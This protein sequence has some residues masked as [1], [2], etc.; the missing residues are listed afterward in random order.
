MRILIISVFFPQ[1]NTIAALRPY[2]WAKYWSQMGHEVTVLT[3][4][5]GKSVTDLKLDMS[6]FTL[7]EISLPGFLEKFI[8]PSKADSI[9]DQSNLFSKTKSNLLKN[10]IKKMVYSPFKFILNKLRKYG[11]FA[12]LRMPD[13]FDLWY[14]SAYNFAKKNNWDL[15]VSSYGPYVSHMVAY[16]LKK[17]KKCSKWIADYRDLWTMNH[18]FSA[19]VCPFNVLENYLEKKFNYSADIITTVSEPLAQILRE[20]YKLNYVRTI[21]NGFDFDDVKSLS[22]ERYWNDENIHIA[23]TG[24]VYEGKQNPEPM[25]QAI[26]ELS[27]SIDAHLLNNF[28]LIFFGKIQPNIVELVKKYNID[29]WVY[30]NDFISRNDILKIQRDANAL[31]FLE[32]N[33]KEG[34][35][36]GKIFEYL[37]SGTQILS[38]GGINPNSYVSNF[39]RESKCGKVLSDNVELIKNELKSLLNSKNK[40]KVDNSFALQYSRKILAEKMLKLLD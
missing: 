19:G 33:G 14:F 9:L 32:F 1:E 22:Q 3:T 27:H 13:K 24:S 10:Y 34:V 6:N 17:E 2:S 15:V 38:I 25:F 23:Y 12:G 40:I 39:I 36:S 11:A 16:K 5:K 26:F 28:Q 4:V 31:L 37:A 30:F 35:F 21:E 20:K 8:F 18:A 7:K 29:K